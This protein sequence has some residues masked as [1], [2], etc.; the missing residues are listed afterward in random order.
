MH[1]RNDTVWQSPILVEKYL[2]GVRRGG[3]PL[4][5]EQLTVMR[6]LV[7]AVAPINS[8]L[9][10]G[11]GD[12]I[13]AAAILDQHPRARGLLAD[14][15]AP[16]LAA[17]REKLASQAAQLTF[18]NLDYA[19]PDWHDAVRVMAPYDAIV[20]GYSIHHQ[21]DARKREIYSEIHALL[22]PGGLFINI[23]HVAPATPWARAIFDEMF[24]DSL[25]ASNLRHGTGLTREEV[26]QEYYNRPDRI[27]NILT[28][29]DAQ[30][31]W[32]REIGYTEVGCYFQV[33]EL[34]VFG[35]RK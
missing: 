5:E 12:G 24:V 26:A 18:L 9:D 23:E 35:G 13:L 29:V 27:A 2:S 19:L 28:P 34:A 3:I 15:S 14:F 32:L 10:L 30:C 25:Y 6:Y 20:S 17:A 7:N 8:F 22:R 33:F 1:E 4:A 11:C 31:E 21:P 16:M